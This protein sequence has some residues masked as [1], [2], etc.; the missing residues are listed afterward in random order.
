V[1]ELFRSRCPRSPRGSSRSRRSRARPGHRTKIAV[2]P[3]TRPSTRS[4]RAS[5]HARQ[6]G[7]R[8]RRGARRGEDRHHHLVEEPAELV[9]NALSPAKVKEVYLYDDDGTALVVVPD[10]QLSLAIGREGQN[11][12][13]AARLTNWRIDIKSET[14]F[15]EEQAAFQAASSAAR[16]TSTATR[17]LRRRMRRSR[18][19]PPR[20]RRTRV[21]GSRGG[22]RRGRRASRRGRG[23]RWRH[24]PARAWRAGGVRRS[25]R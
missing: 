18:Q 6:P 22:P 2:P 9:A 10:Y 21:R 17:S 15:A 12:R 20:R 23:V 1:K 3:P 4:A 7:A 25:R 24:P 11:A 14:Q 8:D 16:S 19:R 5:A 13:L